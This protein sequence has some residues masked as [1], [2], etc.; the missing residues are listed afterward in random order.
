MNLL[1]NIPFIINRR[2]VNNVYIILY[3]SIQMTA[4]YWR[5]KKEIKENK[6]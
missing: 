6:A 5:L 3:A 2:V 1:T 4:R